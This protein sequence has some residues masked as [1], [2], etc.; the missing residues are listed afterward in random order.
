[1]SKFAQKVKRYY[2][3]GLWSAQM[4]RDAYGKGRITAEE[5]A[6]ILDEDGEESEDDDPEPQRTYDFTGMSAAEVVRSLSYRPTKDE[7]QQACDWL[8]LAYTAQMTN[9]Q[10]KAL[11]YEA[12][13]VE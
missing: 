9:A 11:I 3:A 7:L 6:E 12:A 1:M 4:V 10:L 5:M 13:G 8:G 2:D